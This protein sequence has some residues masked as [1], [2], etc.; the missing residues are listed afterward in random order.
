QLE[1]VEP[2][3]NCDIIGVIESIGDLGTI[4]SKASQREINKREITL[5]D[6]SGMSI[7]ITLWGKQAQS[8]NENGDMED[9]PV[10]AAKGVKVSDFGGRSLSLQSSSSMSINPDIPEAHGLRGW[11]DNQGAG[12]SFRAYTSASVGG[13]G[14][15]GGAGAGANLAERR[16]IAQA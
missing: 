1:T 15:G 8:F 14:A 16:T 4:V 11:Y 2:N 7:R 3:Q 9:K 13:S 10:L 12:Q 5:V 6:Q